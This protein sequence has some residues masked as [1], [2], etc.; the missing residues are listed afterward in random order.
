MMD[1]WRRPF[2]FLPIFLAWMLGTS[3]YAEAA[4]LRWNQAR[5]HHRAPAGSVIE[6]SL[7]N[8]AALPKTQRLNVLFVLVDDLRTSIGCYGDANARTPHIDALARANGAVRFSAAYASV[9]TCSPSRTSLLTG[10]R[11]DT[12]RIYDLQ[13]HFRETVPTAVTLPQ[14][15]REAGWL[16]VSYGKIFHESLDDRLSWSGQY[17]R[18]AW[19]DS[20]SAWRGTRN[21]Y[22]RGWWYMEYDSADRARSVSMCP[23]T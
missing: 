22:G 23:R 5:P 6:H 16:S 8:V 17:S 18:P 10:L 3:G 7:Y 1:A 11:P 19:L 9:A 15:F 21:S 2:Q 14:L 20:S 13:T 12:H 4:D